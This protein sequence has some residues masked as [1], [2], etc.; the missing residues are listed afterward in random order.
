VEFAVVGHTEWVEFAR[1]ERP[2]EPGE[3]VHAGETWQAPAGGG[4]V[5]A[6][7]IAKLTGGCRFL[8]ALGH[9]ELGRR[10]KTELEAV[11]V[12]VEAAWRSS[13]QR[14]ALVFLDDEGERTITTIEDRVGPQ[15]VDPLSWETLDWVAGLYFTAGDSGA[16][17]AARV[18]NRLIATVRAG[19]A[20][21]EAGVVVDAVVRSAGDAGEPYHRGEI[22]PTPGAVVSTRGA[23][24]GAIETADGEARE[25][26]A[27]PLPG[28]LVDV[29]GAGDSFAGGVTV[30]LGL[31]WSLDDAVALGAR[32]GAACV[33]GRGPYANQLSSV[34]G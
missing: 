21:A 15:V 23:A 13:P 19:R 6:V 1:V 5:A 31:G 34:D 16:L 22:D 33:A 26:R 3:I 17:R 9:D 32:C 10:T 18:A 11:G 14:R 7:Q 29:Y 30:G 2:P 8:T 20:L 4:A 12:E 25:W 28:P 27:P 24:G